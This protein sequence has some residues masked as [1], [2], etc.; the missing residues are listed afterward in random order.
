MDGGDAL[1]VPVTPTP[2]TLSQSPSASAWVNIVCA[3]S[4]GGEE[5]PVRSSSKGDGEAGLG[6][7]GADSGDSNAMLFRDTHVSQGVKRHEPSCRG[8]WKR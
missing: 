6:V 4:G 5:V 3:S 1:V 7:P 2:E 8:A